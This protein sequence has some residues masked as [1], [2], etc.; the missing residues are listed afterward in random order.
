M[1]AET[2]YAY[3]RTKIYTPGERNESTFTYTRVLKHKTLVFIN[4]NSIVV[5]WVSYENLKIY[6]YRSWINYYQ[7]T[8]N[9]AYLGADTH[10][11]AFKLFT[12]TNY[13]KWVCECV[14][15][16]MCVYVCV[17]AA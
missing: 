4:L 16:C 10:F 1:K 6:I 9:P 2:F 3:T 14:C 7:P 12:L 17:Q 5:D 8:H 15:A 11:Y 13:S